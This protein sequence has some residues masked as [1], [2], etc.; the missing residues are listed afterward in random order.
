MYNNNI[1]IATEKK[2]VDGAI[3][4]MREVT[5]GLRAAADARTKYSQLI[6]QIGENIF[7]LAKSQNPDYEE[8][9]SKLNEQLKQVSEIEK[10]LSEEE[11]RN[12]EDFRDVVERYFVVSRANRT[13]MECKNA[14]AKAGEALEAAKN[15][16]TLEM[17]KATYEKNRFKLEAAIDKAKHTKA[18]ALDN[19]KQSIRDLIEARKKYDAFKIR[20]L[21][22]G[23]TRYGNALK[24]ACDSELTVYKEIQTL[25]NDLKANAPQPSTT[26]ATHEENAE[27]HNDAEAA[28]EG[29]VHADPQ[30]DGFE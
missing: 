27:E 23:W 9:F 12:S 8:G 26:A 19:L 7:E 24:T 16:N 4:D 18:T 14:Y 10:T 28:Q 17:N 29:E 2:G 6:A 1:P 30:S 11:A 25:V 15:K 13:Y 20:R 21:V 3:N 5:H 22:S